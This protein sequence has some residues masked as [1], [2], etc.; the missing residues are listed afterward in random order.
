MNCY[1]NFSREDLIKRIEELE[2]DKE[3]RISSNSELAEGKY[4]M[5]YASKILDSLPDMIS[6]MTADGV[7]VD[8]VSSEEVNHTGMS[9]EKLRGR[10]VD[11]ILVGQSAVN[12]KKNL[13]TVFSTGHGSTAHH[14][15]TL[16]GYTRHYE[17]RIFPLDKKYAL[18]VC[19]DITEAK[20][21]EHELETVKY[22]LNNVEEEIYACKL[23]GTMLYANEQFRVR[24]SITDKI[25]N[26][27][28]YEFW[29]PAGTP[30]LWAERLSKI[31]R[32]KGT[33][34]YT[35]HEKNKRGRIISWDVVAYLICDYFTGKEIIWFFA[36]DVTMRLASESKA[37]EMNLILN[38]I[39]NN[40]PIYLYVKDPSNEF[41]YLY[42]NKA[43]E[44]YS[45]IPA[46]KAIGHTDYEIFPNPLDAERFRQDDLKLLQKESRLSIFEQ[47]VTLTGETRYVSTSKILVPIE[48][49]LPLIIG[50]SWDITEQKTTEREIVDARI[51]AEESDRLKSAF[52][53]NMSHE[54]RTP[55]NAI[56]GFSK[57]ISEA[58]T[59]ED[60]AQFADIVDANSELLLQLI[61]DILDISKIE[62]GTLEFKYKMM[63]INELLRAEWEVHRVRTHAGVALIFDEKIEN[64]EFVCDQNR[65]SQVLTNL[66]SN[67]IKF[68]T[69]GEIRFG[70]E[71]DESQITFYVKDTGSGIPDAKL[72]AI[73]ERFIKLNDFAAGTGLG[74]SISKMIVEKFG[75]Q[76][77]VD[78][79][80]GEGTS[81][82]FSV[83]YRRSERLET[84]VQIQPAQVDVVSN[85]RQTILIAEDIESDYLLVEALI[86]NRF[87]V[88]RA[89]D[90]QE[91]MDLF[92]GVK[93]DLVLMN[94]K[95]PV[96]DGYEATRTIRHLSPS[97][98]IIAM[99]V[100]TFGSDLDNAFNAGCNDYVIKPL[101]QFAL[102][103]KLDA[104]LTKSDE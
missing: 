22:A 38:S 103:K 82:F 101:S 14:D 100:F 7:V 96:V 24:H 84:A 16:N 42:W 41:R 63:N 19:R 49:R 88:I 70:F 44:E 12:L 45:H 91:A 64:V 35:V 40:I 51:K 54:I 99:S 71:L 90:G 79:H 43:F 2:A 65:L 9:A 52:L 18:C 39:L 20:E 94:M 74:L 50:V 67:A 32:D 85:E 72:H 56:V 11:T 97:V 4:R 58:E 6:I 62:A 102:N 8:V 86:N 92:V 59:E 83:P 34:K 25:T 68:T 21:A 36:R 1:D 66:I 10:K 75:G 5:K 37:N 77:W 57:L 93:P 29:F 48:N 47:Y 28:M 53:A 73:F 46:S 89:N 98:P 3:H 31:R 69:K 27:R 60:K 61:N 104:Y 23:D 15:I 26:Y 81:F 30:K 55:L 13:D 76:I 95:L 33:H 78:S 87:R 17:N 80:V